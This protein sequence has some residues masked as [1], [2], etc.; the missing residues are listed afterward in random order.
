MGFIKEPDGVTL[1]VDKIKL[2]TEIENRIKKFIENS[3]K[4]N[5]EFLESLKRR[6][7]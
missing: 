7:E 3:K 1:V 2:T 5:K 4:K 6:K